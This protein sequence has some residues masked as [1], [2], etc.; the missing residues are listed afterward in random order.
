[1]KITRFRAF[2]SIPFLMAEGAGSEQR[3]PIG[4]V[5]FYGT[6]ISVLLTLFVVPAV[7]TLVAGEHRSPHYLRDLVSRLRA[8][9]P[10]VKDEASHVGEASPR[11]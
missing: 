6:T 8:T 1:M 7:Y 4:V 2:G 10:E 9:A 5:V 3:E 11:A